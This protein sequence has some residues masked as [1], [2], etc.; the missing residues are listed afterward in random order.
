RLRR[1]L[2]GDLDNIVMRALAKEPER[3]YASAEQLAEDVGRYLRGEVVLAR[4]DTVGYRTLK[5]VRR[6]RTGVAAASVIA[7]LLVSF[8]VITLR[9]ARIV[10]RERDAAREERDRAELAQLQAEEVSEFLMGLFAASDPSEARGDTVTAVELLDRGE[11]RV[12]QLVN[13][14][15]RASC[16]E[17]G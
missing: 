7:I 5:F 12:E 14:I 11:E 2:R 1:T 9:Q 8:S 13:Q 16:R 6:H 15:G 4:K 10:A 17:R 3:R